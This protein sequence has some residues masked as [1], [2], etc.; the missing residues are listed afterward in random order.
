MVLFQLGGGH[1]SRP[2][3]GAFLRRRLSRQNLVFVYFPLP[4]HSI[5]RAESSSARSAQK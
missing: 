3:R 4:P 1:D 2:E 5:L